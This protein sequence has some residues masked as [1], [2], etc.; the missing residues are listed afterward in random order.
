MTTYFMLRNQGRQLIVKNR[1]IQLVG[2]PTDKFRSYTG[3]PILLKSVL[4]VVRLLHAGV[5]RDGCISMTRTNVSD[6]PLRVSVALLWCKC[7]VDRLVRRAH[8]ETYLH[9]LGSRV[10]TAWGIASFRGS[11]G[12]NRS[13]HTMSCVKRW[14]PV[15]V[16]LLSFV[17]S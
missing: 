16:C 13:L 7:R 12:R 14:F 6:I 8:L 1:I 4:S 2:I 3:F 17:E 10:R 9:G 11:C 15:F 5:P